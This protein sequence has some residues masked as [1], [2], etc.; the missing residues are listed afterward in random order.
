MSRLGDERV[1]LKQTDGEKAGLHNLATK[2]L[3]S[4]ANAEQS[5]RET[6]EAPR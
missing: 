3:G 4:H 1:C 6:F 2:T 5:K